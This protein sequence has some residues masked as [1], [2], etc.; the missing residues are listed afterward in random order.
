MKLKILSKTEGFR[1]AGYSFSSSQAT[2]IPVKD[3]DQAKLDAL[4]SDPGLVVVEVADDHD[5]SSA[6]GKPDKALQA[7]LKSVEELTKALDDEK[8]DHA[9][10]AKKLEDLSAKGKTDGKA[11]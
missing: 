10:T 7:A 2:L 8:A 6:K 11:K 4:K 9:A 1:R 3:L 5:E